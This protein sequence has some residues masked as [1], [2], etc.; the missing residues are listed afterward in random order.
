L[1]AVA[2]G[3]IVLHPL[4]ADLPFGEQERALMPGA[5]RKVVLATS[6]AETSLTIEG[7]RTVVDSGLARR[8]EHHAASGMGRL[9]TV[10]VARAQADQRA[11]RA[12]RTAPGVCYRLYS[13]QD[14]EALTAFAPPDACTSTLGAQPT[15]C[16]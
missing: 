7:V 4:Y 1:P 11:G 5:R 9:V 3:A 6:I 13:R 12:G 10:R 8:I 2:A 15:S 16:S 14:Y